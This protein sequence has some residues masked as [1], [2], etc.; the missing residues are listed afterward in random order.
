MLESCLWEAGKGETRDSICL[1]WSDSTWLHIH[2]MSHFF[3]K[4]SM[5]LAMWH[6]VSMCRKHENMFLRHAVMVV[7]SRDTCVRGRLYAEWTVRQIGDNI[8]SCTHLARVL[9]YNDFGWKDTS[10][11]KAATGAQGPMA[12]V[13]VLC[14]WALAMISGWQDC[15][16]TQSVCNE[17]KAPDTGGCL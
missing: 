1:M 7:F 10:C 11:L 13:I 15:F 4:K 17:V 6:A 14:L 8:H 3:K 12:A 2:H 9:T 16:V 5:T